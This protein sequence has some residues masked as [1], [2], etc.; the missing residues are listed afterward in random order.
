MELKPNPTFR[1]SWLLTAR[2]DED[3]TLPDGSR[4][5]WRTTNFMQESLLRG[6]LTGRNG[7][8]RRSPLGR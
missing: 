2:R 7:R 6:G 1:P 5:L 8:G 3:M 4:D